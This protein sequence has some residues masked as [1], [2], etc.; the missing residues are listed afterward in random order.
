[1]RSADRSRG[2][3][4]A[5]DL[6]ALP[7]DRA[8]EVIDGEIVDKALPSF[9]HGSAQARLSGA[10]FPFQG[11]P[12]GPRGPGGW[13]LASEVE[14]E[15]ETHEVYRH[16]AVGWRR[17]RAP[18]MPGGRPVRLRPDWVCEV[19]SPSNTANDTIKKLR[20]LHRN[21]VPN[22]WLLD[23]DAGTLRVLRWS[24]DGYLEVLS[25]TA[26]ETV[27]AEPFEGIELPLPAVFGLE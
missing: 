18:Q 15:Y 1:M 7:P 10:L 14:V 25:S 23:P 26:D 2:L 8:A 6:Q 19:L 27:H 11:P 5:A 21:G 22:Y 3:A 9:A 17:D 4:T 24:S 20:V 12:G 13:W 16:D